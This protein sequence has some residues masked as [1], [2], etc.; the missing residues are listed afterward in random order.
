MEGDG[1]LQKIVGLSKIVSNHIAAVC[2]AACGK[3]ES[4]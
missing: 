4:Q 1:T 3:E 2:N